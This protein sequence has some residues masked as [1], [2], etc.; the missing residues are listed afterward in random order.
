MTVINVQG[1]A[2]HLKLWV[3]LLIMVHNT[4]ISLLLLST[5][6]KLNY[7]NDVK[8]KNVTW[9]ALKIL[10][11]DC[12]MKLERVLW[13]LCLHTTM[14]RERLKALP[15]EFIHNH[16]TRDSDCWHGPFKA[17]VV[18]GNRVNFV[19]HGDRPIP[20]VAAKEY[21]A[22]WLICS[23]T[24]LESRTHDLLLFVFN[25]NSFKR[26]MSFCWCFFG[27]HQLY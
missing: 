22:I 18:T 19:R 25:V 13:Q 9:K 15:V 20:Y 14:R 8:K 16:V 3:F 24:A 6:S 2:N 26:N 11:N 1:Q 27:S 4:M 7:N 21:G 5:S 12:L 23:H 17:E 10:A